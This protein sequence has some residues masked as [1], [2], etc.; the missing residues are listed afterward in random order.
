MDVNCILNTD[1]LSGLKE[2]PD[3]CIDCCVT[4]PPYFRMRDY[5]VDGQIGLENTPEE[6][7]SK[8]AEIFQE[9]FRV[10]KNTGTLWL[11]LGDCYNG[12]GKAGTGKTSR[13]NLYF[14]KKYKNFGKTIT[15]AT[16][17][18]PVDLSSLKPKDLIG[19]PWMAAFALRSQ[20]WY[21]R[22]DII[23]QK[24]NCSPE[25]VRDRC[26][27]SHE[28]IFLMSKARK[29]YYDYK[30]I[31]EKSKWSEKDKRSVN[32]PTQSRRMVGSLYQCKHQGVYCPDG[33][34]NKRDVW[35]VNTAGFKDAHF[36]TYPPAL[37]TDCIKAGCPPGGIVLDP[38]MGAGTTAV[39]AESLG[40]NY[41]G[42]ELNSEYVEI[43]NNR[44]LKEREARL[45]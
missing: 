23:W 36:A 7:V 39:V 2:L 31:S 6:Y 10:L 11:N 3:E 30:A 1:C 8:L 12:S 35:T 37:I 28:H 18:I 32:G 14:S 24:T 40:R 26:T 13:D 9:V 25:S 20:G 43:A 42:F 21:L 16:A 33:L 38:F 29:Y 27:K 5:G 15:R 19:I 44:I 45:N 17:G 41:I 34:R 4:S 22:N